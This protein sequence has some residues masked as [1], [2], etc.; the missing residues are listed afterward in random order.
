MSTVRLSIEC[1]HKQ[2]GVIT[3]SPCTI[4]GKW[5]PSTTTPLH[6]PSWRTLSRT[7]RRAA[8][9]SKP[10]AAENHASQDTYDFLQSDTYSNFYFF[11]SPPL[12]S[13]F[14]LILEKTWD[15]ICR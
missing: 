7:L 6:F 10:T 1:K 15:A 13:S 12:F 3:Q 5:T 9:V 2:T 8:G 14:S 4:V 11:S